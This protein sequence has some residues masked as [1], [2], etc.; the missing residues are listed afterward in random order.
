MKI[1]QSSKEN[2][3]LWHLSHDTPSCHTQL[4]LAE[5]VAWLWVGVAKELAFVSPQL[6]INAY[7]ISPEGAGCQYFSHLELQ[8]EEYR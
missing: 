8:V 7:P 4:S 3:I 5:A 2:S 1:Y 6:S